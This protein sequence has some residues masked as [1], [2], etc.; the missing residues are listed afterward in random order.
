MFF[1][2][3]KFH[4]HHPVKTIVFGVGVQMMEG[5]SLLT[6]R[7]SGSPSTRQKRIAVGFQ[8]R[9]EYTSNGDIQGLLVELVT[10]GLGFE[11]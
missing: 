5:R 9:T 10:V 8:G 3:E 1:F 7:S 11:G 4:E 6:I 2:P